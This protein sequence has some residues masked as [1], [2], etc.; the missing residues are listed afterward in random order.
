MM[1]SVEITLPEAARSTRTTPPLDFIVLGDDWGAHPSSVQH[2]FRRV[3]R[4]HRTLWVNTLEL[5][6]PR[7]DRADA[8]RVVRKVRNWWSPADAP[9]RATTDTASEA[10]RL[11][12]V[13]PPMLPW[14]RPH[15]V[16]L[17][18]RASM[19]RVVEQAAAAWGLQRP[20]VVTTVPNGV[21]ALGV[22]GA[23]AMIYYCVDDFTQWPGIDTVAAE[24]LERAARRGR[25]RAGDERR[26]RGEQGSALGAGGVVAARRRCG[27]SGPCL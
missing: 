2:I 19:R 14:M 17:L 5:R 8:A 24:H 26:P 4:R 16:R 21:D 10:L 18:N 13:A 9:Q 12:V 7:L 23:R 3:A 1:Q 25:H 22:A 6:P 20:V 11:R 27:A 15:P